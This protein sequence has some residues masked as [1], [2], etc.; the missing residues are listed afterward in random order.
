M[1][2]N[3][4]DLMVFVE[5]DGKLKSI[6]FATSHQFQMSM[7][8]KDTTNKDEGNGMWSSYEAGLMSWTMQSDNLMSDSGENGIG[9]NELI[10]IAVKREPVMVAFSLQT[11]NI[12]YQKKLGEVF[13]APE[14][15]WTPDTNNQLKGK[16]LITSLQITAQ[17]GELAT[18]TVTFTGCG[19]VQKIGKGIEKAATIKAALDKPIA[20]ISTKETATLKN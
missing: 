9:V 12:D 5:V 7:N 3:G 1:K 15:G 18:S 16:A 10:D 17:N 20:S 2:L 8:P 6:A 11:D 19:N 13:K 4:S 14:G